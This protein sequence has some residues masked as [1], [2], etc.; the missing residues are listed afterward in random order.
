MKSRTGSSLYN[1]WKNLY[2]GNV[3][4]YSQAQLQEK[5]FLHSADD[6]QRDPKTGKF[7]G[8]K[9]GSVF[10]AD[11]AGSDPQ[12]WALSYR[13]LLKDKGVN[14]DDLKTMI[15]VTA[16]ISRGNKLLGAI[17]D[18]YILPNPSKQLSKERFGNIGQV[19]NDAAGIIN[20]DDPRAWRQKLA[21][22]WTNF[23]EAVGVSVVPLFIKNVLEPLTKALRDM[24]Q[25]AIIHPTRMKYIIEGIAGIGAALVG[26]GVLAVGGALYMALGPVGWLLAGLGGLATAVAILKE[27]L[28]EATKPFMKKAVGGL[29]SVLPTTEYESEVYAH[30]LMKDFLTRRRKAAAPLP[31]GGNIHKISNTIT[32]NL[33]GRQITRAVVDNLVRSSTFQTSVGGQDTRGTWLSPGAMVSA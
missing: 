16:E 29:L 31:S 17:L 6:E 24:S 28:L 20:E 23:E 19:S 27:P 5:W 30:E 12:K 33:D 10:N 8:F 1:F 22:Q 18:E 14:V 32:L 7:Q 26:L 21:K 25:W 11:L 13:D 15:D 9:V 3:S 4:S 2:Q